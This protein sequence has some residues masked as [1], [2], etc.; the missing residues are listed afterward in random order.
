VD[1]TA[2]TILTSV[3]VGFS[4][5]ILTVLLMLFRL[6]SKTD[7]NFRADM[8]TQREDLKADL[9]HQREDMNAKHAEL[10]ADLRHQRE[11]LNAKH[12]ELKADLRDLREDLNAKHAELK[13]DI[14]ELRTGDIAELRTGQTDIRGRLRNL[15]LDV[16]VLKSHALGLGPF[17]AERDARTRSAGEAAPERA[18]AT[19]GLD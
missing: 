7:A 3:L 4:G 19:T 10:K 15:E 12:A 5:V 13:A 6:I 18:A 1:D 14:A 11:D 2:V 8:K 16:G 9:R 17:M